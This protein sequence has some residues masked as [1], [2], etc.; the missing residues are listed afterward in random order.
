MA[1]SRQANGIRA[2]KKS[3]FFGLGQLKYSLQFFHFNRKQ[4]KS[5]KFC[6][7]RFFSL[8]IF[9][10]NQKQIKVIN[11]ASFSL[12]LALKV[13]KIENFFVSDFGICVISLLVMYK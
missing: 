8:L 13:H 2:L 10:S 3:R 11:F 7:F 12:R 9:H 4:N 6:V 1:S 5:D